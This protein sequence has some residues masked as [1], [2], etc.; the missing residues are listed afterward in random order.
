M[1]WDTT[2]THIENEMGPRPCLTSSSSP[3]GHGRSGLVVIAGGAG[4]ILDRLQLRLLFSRL[5]V[6]LRE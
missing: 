6:D 3:A 1:T 4:D 2:A 5:S